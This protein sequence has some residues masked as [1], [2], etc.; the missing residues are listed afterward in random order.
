MSKLLTMDQMQE[1]GASAVR[2]ERMWRLSVDNQRTRGD[3]LKL[4][5]RIPSDWETPFLKFLSPE[6][7]ADLRR[8]A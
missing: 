1:C 6:T 7:V 5:H 8:M 2:F 3:L 4:F